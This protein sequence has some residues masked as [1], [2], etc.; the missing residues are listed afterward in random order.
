MQVTWTKVITLTL[1]CGVFS[2]QAKAGDRFEK[3]NKVFFRGG[4]SSLTSGRGTEVFTD[5]LGA[6]TSNGGKGG[7]SAAA[8]LDLG[9]MK[10]QALLDTFSLAGEVF[11]EFSRFSNAR[12]TQATSALLGAAAQSSVD[13]TELN[14]GVSP[15]VKWDTLGRFRPWLIPVGLNFLVSSPPSNDT[16]Y[17]DLG[18]NFGTGVDFEVLPWLNVGVDGR[19]VLGFEFNNTN[20]SYLSLGGNVG[21][22]F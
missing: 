15:K 7:F 14:V 8:G 1:L 11:I 2:N 20:T 22:N 13:L 21:L 18:V 4:Y 6:T 3:N 9:M 10:P 16:T 19:Y 12:V 5:T 17:L